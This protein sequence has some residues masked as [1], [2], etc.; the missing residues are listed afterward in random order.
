MRVRP[1][2]ESDIPAIY[3]G[4]QDPLISQFTP[5]PYPYEKEVAIDFV[6]AS[7]FSFL[8]HTSMNFAVDYFD[9]ETTTFAGT[10]GLHSLQQRDHMGEI[11][12]WLSKEM[13][14][15]GICALAVKTLTEYAINVMGFRRIEALAAVAN[16]PSHR[17][18]ER[19]GFVRDGVLKNRVTRPDGSQIDMV[20]YSFT[21]DFSG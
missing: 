6:R 17:V 14:G 20:L 3:D 19:A 13:R 4:C 7:H 1:L 5:I 12:Y 8:D 21:R 10:V 16:T 9:G 18:L 2:S 15:K 11:G